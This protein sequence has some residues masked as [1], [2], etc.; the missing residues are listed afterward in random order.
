MP[1]SSPAEKQDRQLVLDEMITYRLAR[2]QARL[3]AQA[4]RILKENGGLTLTQWRILVLLD[5]RGE[6]NLA[7]LVRETKF[8]KAQLSRAVKT[9]LQNGLLTSKANETD[10]RQ[11]LLAMTGT[12]RAAFEKALPHMRG[13][14]QILLAS[15]SRQQR[16]D[17]FAALDRIEA[18]LTEGGT[19][20]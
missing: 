4:T 15:L 17:L 10:Q 16:E 1:D 20:R 3:N 18:A 9:M 2:L 11:I 19:Q 14:Q 8:D 6:A 12:G 7:Q 5:L 13:R